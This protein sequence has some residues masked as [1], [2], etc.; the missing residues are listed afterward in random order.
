MILLELNTELKSFGQ[1]G[2][3]LTAKI[4]GFEFG[5]VTR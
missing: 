3:N 2:Q 1:E 5:D 4:K